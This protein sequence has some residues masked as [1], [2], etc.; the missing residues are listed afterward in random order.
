LR[1]GGKEWK[2]KGSSQET[3]RLSA[4]EEGQKKKSCSGKEIDWRLHPLLEGNWGED[5]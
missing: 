5:P 2:K 3:G 4:P 1:G